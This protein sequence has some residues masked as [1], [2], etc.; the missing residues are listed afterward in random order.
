MVANSSRNTFGRYRSD[1]G[2]YD[3]TSAPRKSPG[4]D[5]KSSCHFAVRDLRDGF[6]QLHGYLGAS[7]FEH[8]VR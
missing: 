5:P 2:N 3:S 1:L 4:V 7:F 8:S 6:C